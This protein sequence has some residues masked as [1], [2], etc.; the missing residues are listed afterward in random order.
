MRLRN[1]RP[2]M[3]FIV[4]FFRRPGKVGEIQTTRSFRDPPARSGKSDQFRSKKR[5]ARLGRRIF[6]NWIY[7]RRC[8]LGRKGAKRGRGADVF[9]G[10]CSRVGELFP[11]RKRRVIRAEEMPNAAGEIPLCCGRISRR[12]IPPPAT[13]RRNLGRTNA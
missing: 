8:I 9:S 10:E 12:G 7:Y 2:S 6:E 3:G 4:S 11:G 13:N 5:R 1:R